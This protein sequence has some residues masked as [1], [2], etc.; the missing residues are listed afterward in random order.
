MIKLSTKQ[1]QDQF[2]QLIEGLKPQTEYTIADEL[3][4]SGFMVFA[5][6]AFESVEGKAVYLT[7]YTRGFQKVAFVMAGPINSERTSTQ[8]LIVLASENW[9]NL[10]K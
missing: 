7:I 4:E 10:V 5:S 1:Q 8:E 9:A 2:E 6:H 3:I